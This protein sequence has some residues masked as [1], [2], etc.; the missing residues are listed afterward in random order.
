MKLIAG[1]SVCEAD[2]RVVSGCVCLCGPT[3]TAALCE[4]VLRTVVL[5]GAPLFVPVLLSPAALP[6]G[7]GGGSP[8]P[9][10][11]RRWAPLGWG[12]PQ[13]YPARL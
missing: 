3:V 2:C 4:A 13:P 7:W 9:Y 11:A 6:G 1:G 12:S 5:P 8:Q 10:P